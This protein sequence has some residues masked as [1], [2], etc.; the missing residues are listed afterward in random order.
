MDAITL[1]GDEQPFY[2]KDETEPEKPKEE[3]VKLRLI[4][5]GPGS[6][7]D[8]DKVD[9]FEAVT[10]D[11]AG[12]N[13]LVATDSTGKLPSAIVPAASYAWATWTPTW[14][15]FSSPPTGG[16]AVYVIIGEFV[17]CHMWGWA[18]GTSNSNSLEFSLPVQAQQS[19]TVCGS[20][21]A[22][23]NGSFSANPCRFDILNGSTCKVYRTL[24]GD[25]WTASGQ[26]VCYGTF[27]YRKAI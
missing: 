2:E 16:G 23:D 14:T 3:A 8:S 5:Q 26:K 20:G 6:Q 19:N 18:A 11:K 9:G 24:Q 25:V 7:L 12:P 13:V 4:P 1:Q 22:F 15:G 10:A 27:F 17:A 21:L